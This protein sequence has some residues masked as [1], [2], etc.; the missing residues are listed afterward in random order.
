MHSSIVVVVVVD[1]GV[2]H[3]YHEGGGLHENHHLLINYYIRSR[4][5]LLHFFETIFLLEMNLLTPLGL[6]GLADNYSNICISFFI[7]SHFLTALASIEVDK[8]KSVSV[9]CFSK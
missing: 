6:L 8:V 9:N 3:L 4:R 1:V 7:F 5:S 2:G